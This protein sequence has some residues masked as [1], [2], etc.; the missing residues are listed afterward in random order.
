MSI[1]NPIFLTY[2][3]TSLLNWSFALT[4]I[5][6]SKIKTNSNKRSFARFKF[7]K[8]GVFTLEMSE[9]V[10]IIFIRRT[11][12]LTFIK[13]SLDFNKS[14]RVS[15]CLFSVLVTTHLFA[16][17]HNSKL[18]KFVKKCAHEI[19]P[20]FFERYN[21]FKCD[22]FLDCLIRQHHYFC[23]FVIYTFQ[24]VYFWLIFK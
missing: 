18:E 3:R 12:F 9:F 5:K 14:G 15:K 20:S 23:C 22:F 21:C 4:P 11:H 8:T 24:Y 13:T 7:T 2:L 1:P 16:F 17:I 19:F 10:Y 6:H